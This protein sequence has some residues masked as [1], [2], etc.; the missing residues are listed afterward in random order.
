M[1]PTTSW[2]S[3]G[4]WTEGAGYGPKP[5]LPSAIGWAGGDAEA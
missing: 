3:R 4:C 1:T 5:I 2:R